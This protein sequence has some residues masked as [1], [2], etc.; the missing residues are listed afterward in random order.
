MFV[1][2]S[3]PRYLNR[4][5]QYVRHG[6]CLYAVGVIP[7]EKDPTLV[8]AKLVTRYQVS[9]CRQTRLLRRRVGEGNVVYLRYRHSFIL[10]ASGGHHQSF[11]TDE[12][13]CD[14]RERPILISGYSIGVRRGEPWV[15]IA[16]ARFAAITR[17]AQA[18]ALHNKPKVTAFFASITPLKFQ[19][20]IQQQKRLL[21][22]VN[23]R[24]RRGG[25]PIIRVEE[26]WQEREKR[27]VKRIK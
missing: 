15:E 5:A 17:E 12:H 18:M 10:L 4:C 24:R 25:L 11:I 8:D 14:C 1:V 9:R 6:Y 2:N 23:D 26:I 22:A 27:K 20:V 16:P 7:S 3:F 19:G 13:P 21:D